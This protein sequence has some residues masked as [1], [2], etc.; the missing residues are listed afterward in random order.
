MQNRV[1]GRPRRDHRADRPFSTATSFAE[2]V[3]DPASK[4]LW[5]LKPVVRPEVPPVKDAKAGRNPIDAFVLA[6]LEEKGLTFSPEADRL[7]L[8]RRLS[9]DLTGLPPTP[10]E[11]TLS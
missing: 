2:K 7:T 3:Q 10:E 6:K 8:L 11:V 5:S 4:D 9:F 1:D